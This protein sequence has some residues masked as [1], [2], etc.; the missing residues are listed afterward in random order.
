M[1]WFWIMET[2]YFSQPESGISQMTTA[3]HIV[4]Q[5][6]NLGYPMCD[7]KLVTSIM[8]R[9]FNRNIACAIFR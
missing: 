8:T 3:I 9:T 6:S 5:N 7:W 1:F 2:G 4:I